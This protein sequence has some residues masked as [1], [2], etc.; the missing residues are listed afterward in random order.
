METM[1]GINSRQEGLLTGRFSLVGGIFIREVV[2]MG[3][4]PFA[5]RIFSVSRGIFTQLLS[6]EATM[7]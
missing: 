5:S 6:E 3:K 1:K 2:V 7:P 4:M